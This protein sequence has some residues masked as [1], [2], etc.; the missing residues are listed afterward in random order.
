MARNEK[1]RQQKLAKRK[2]K[3]AAKRTSMARGVTRDAMLRQEA[4]L[5]STLPI[6][7]CSIPSPEHFDHMGI[8]TVALARGSLSG[9]V[10]VALFLVDI[11]CLG[12]KNAGLLRMPG[13]QFPDHI[14]SL[15]MNESREECDPACAK[16]LVLDSIAYAN[17]L[18]F[19]P[20]KDYRLA[21][22]L[23]GDIDAANCDREFVFG[24]NSKPKY[25]SGPNDDHAM[26]RRVIT[27]LERNCG[28]GNFE[29]L[30]MD[31]W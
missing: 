2:R 17:D 13:D 9:E 29:V 12:V 22:L 19:T 11:L 23:F 3:R 31:A 8:G 25:I 24:D 30:L 5:A 15:E 18:G 10:T 1:T 16:K 27:T 6:L 28:A 20:Q 14:R 7:H 21:S 4:K 26:I